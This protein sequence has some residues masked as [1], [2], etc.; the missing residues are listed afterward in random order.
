M[1]TPSIHA[2]QLK[3]H[4]GKQIEDKKVKVFLQ[5]DD[6]ILYMQGP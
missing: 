6:M 3:K 4:D 1:L 2:K 5:T